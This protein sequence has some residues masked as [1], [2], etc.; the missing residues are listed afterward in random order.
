MSGMLELFTAYV[1]RITE[2]DI[3]DGERENP[4]VRCDHCDEPD[5]VAGMALGNVYDGY[6]CHGCLL[7]EQHE[8]FMTSGRYR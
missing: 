2:L 5:E 1:E 3:H 6:V 7:D 4:Y 8:H